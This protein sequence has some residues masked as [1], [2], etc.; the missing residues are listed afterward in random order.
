MNG[1][2]ISS[3]KRPSEGDAVDQIT[4]AMFSLSFLEYFTR[5]TF[6]E[7][8]LR[9]L[10]IYNDWCQKSKIESGDKIPFSMGSILGFLFVG[11]LWAKENWIDL[12][13]EDDWQKVAGDW[14]LEGSKIADSKKPNPSVRHVVRRLRNSLGHANVYFTVNST[15]VKK[16]LDE[17]TVRFHDVNQ[18]DTSDTFDATISCTEMFL[19]VKKYQSII[20]SSVSAELGK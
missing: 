7:N 6:V 4:H 2:Y 15:D 10:A 3:S 12:L 8:D 19:L 14:G 16:L 17:T 11:I 5:R 20:H 1:D 9:A 18:R 13:P